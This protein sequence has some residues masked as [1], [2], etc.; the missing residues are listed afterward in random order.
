MDGTPYEVAEYAV[1]VAKS[2]AE[3]L[4][5]AI[6]AAQDMARNAEMERDLILT[7]D[8]NGEAFKDTPQG[9]KWAS[10]QSSLASTIKDLEILEKAAAFNP[11]EVVR[12]YP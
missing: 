8:C 6:Q 7:G 1:R 2:L 5:G 11:K 10:V 4:Q 12:K 9:R 3:V